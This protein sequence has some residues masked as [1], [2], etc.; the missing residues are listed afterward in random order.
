M[1]ARLGQNLGLKLLSLACSFALFLY[2]HKQQTSTLQFQ[3][4]LA[5]LLDEAAMLKRTSIYAT[6]INEDILAVA[7]LGSYPLE[8]MQRYEESYQLAGGVGS[9]VDHYTVTGRSARLNHRLQNSVTWARHNLV[10]DGSF[11]SG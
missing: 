9:L 11:R 6:D 3:V 4:P 5:I 10:T 7:K 8:K 1:M 2:V